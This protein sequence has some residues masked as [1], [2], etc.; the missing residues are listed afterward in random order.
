MRVRLK[1]PVFVA[2]IA[3]SSACGETGAAEDADYDASIVLTAEDRYT[4]DLLG[5]VVD[6]ARLQGRV[7]AL[8]AMLDP[9]VHIFDSSRL[10]RLGSYGRSGDGPGEFRDPEQ[11]VVDPTGRDAG[12]L[13]LD[14]VHQRLTRLPLDEIEAGVVVDPETL[15]M[16]GPDAGSLVR[17][18]DGRW[19]AGGWIVEGRVARYRQDRVYDRTIVGFPPDAEAPGMTLAQ[20]YESRV[21]VDPAGDRL[22]AATAFGGLLEIFDGDGVSVSVATVPD[23]FQ[24]KWRQGR[25]RAGKAVMAVGPETRYGFSDLAATKR[26]LYGLFSGRSVMEDGNPWASREVQ[27]YTWDAQYVRSL[28]LDRVAEAIAVDSSDTWL[29]ASGPDPSPWVGRFRLPESR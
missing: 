5:R 4:D 19:F 2:F 24:P 13:I 17:A 22:A 23:P 9:S 25:S 6:L 16:D 21:V 18:P 28:Y 20:A 3:A 10:R 12:V 8:D 29:Y 27:V 14:G 7:I 15:L 26:F 11:I 1:S